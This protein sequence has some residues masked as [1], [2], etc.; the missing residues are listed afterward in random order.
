[1]N[2]LVQTSTPSE[3]QGRVMSAS[4]MV[5]SGPQTLSIGF[6]AIAIAIVDY[7]ILLAAMTAVLLGCATFLLVKSDR[8]G[9]H[10]MRPA[11]SGT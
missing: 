2:T 5:L 11:R 6:G 7:R 1:M 4:G 3:L 10:P 8:S 9:R